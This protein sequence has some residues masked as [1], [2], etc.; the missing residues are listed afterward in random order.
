M[1]NQKTKGAG[2]SRV[3]VSLSL[4]LSQQQSENHREGE[5][6]VG[7]V[8]TLFRARRRWKLAWFPLAT[9][10]HFC[11]RVLAVKPSLLGI[12]RKHVEQLGADVF[13]H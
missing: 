5:K 8:A 13:S 10:L 1:P 9:T 11:G 6:L 3:F 7:L 2:F 12:K 4:S